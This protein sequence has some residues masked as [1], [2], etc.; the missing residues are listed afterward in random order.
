MNPDLLTGSNHDASLRQ[1]NCRNRCEMCGNSTPWFC[2]GCHTY[3]CADFKGDK[4]YFAV[5]LGTDDG[6]IVVCK[7]TC[8]LQLHLKRLRLSRFMLPVEGIV[9]FILIF[10]ETCRVWVLVQCLQDLQQ[11]CHPQKRLRE[12]AGCRRRAVRTGDSS[13]HTSQHPQDKHCQHAE[14]IL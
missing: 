13:Y 4:G 12:G 6:E 1:K 2:V 3:V 9:G 8:C 7:K 14:P 10:P 5:R 11:P